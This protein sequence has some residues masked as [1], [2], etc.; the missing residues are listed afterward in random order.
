MPLHPASKDNCRR[1]QNIESVFLRIFLHTTCLATNCCC[2]YCCSFPVPKL[3]L[4]MRLSVDRCNQPAPCSLFLFD[5]PLRVLFSHQP[6][7]LFMPGKY[8]PKPLQSFPLSRTPSEPMRASAPR[9]LHGDIS[10]TMP[11]RSA[12]TVAP[13][14]QLAPPRDVSA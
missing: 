10:S 5:I 7:M 3:D 2:C 9:L 11:T 8:P 6:T 4:L 12:G 13:S 1:L 14:L